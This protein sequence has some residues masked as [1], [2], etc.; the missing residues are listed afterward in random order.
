M[1]TPRTAEEVVA[2][3]KNLPAEKLRDFLTALATGDLEAAKK[4]G[5]LSRAELIGLQPSGES[6]QQLDG[7]EQQTVFQLVRETRFAALGALP[8]AVETLRTIF[9]SFAC[10]G[11]AEK[12][13]GPDDVPLP[14]PALTPHEQEAA[15]RKVM[16]AIAAARVPNPKNL[17][18]KRLGAVALVDLAKTLDV[19]T[20]A[21][22]YREPD[23]AESEEATLKQMAE[24][25]GID[26]SGYG[27]PERTLRSVK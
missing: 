7:L 8:E 20:L 10:V 17:E 1:S 15:Q 23:R 4:V 5:G 27:A 6:G 12:A 21:A 18:Q 13:M 24:E 2:K 25:Q 11:D 19:F 26:L 14:D 22:A 3:L 9:T 16:S